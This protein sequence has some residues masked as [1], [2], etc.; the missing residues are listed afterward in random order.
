MINPGCIGLRIL[1]IFGLDRPRGANQGFH[2]PRGATH[3][4][5]GAKLHKKIALLLDDSIMTM[6]S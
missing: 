4:P 5:R 1:S 6:N 2:R 3:R